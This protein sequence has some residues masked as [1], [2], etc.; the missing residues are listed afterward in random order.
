MKIL[1]ENGIDTVLPV[2]K[3]ERDLTQD[4]RRVA[5]GVGSDLVDSYGSADRVEF[6][7]A[8]IDLRIRRSRARDGEEAG[9]MLAESYRQEIEELKLKKAILEDPQAMSRAHRINTISSRVRGAA[10]VAVFIAAGAAFAVAGA[11]L[12]P[13]PVDES[14]PAPSVDCEQ[15]STTELPN[16]GTLESQTDG[17]GNLA[18]TCA[19]DGGVNIHISIGT[20]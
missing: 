16:R 15:V 12:R 8:K 5:L 20:N 11:E 7:L 2:R 14:H 1:L 13:T 9:D 6:Q 3:N 10:A 17:L 19:T 4:E 18:I